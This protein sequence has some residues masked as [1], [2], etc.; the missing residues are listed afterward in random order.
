VERFFV[1]FCYTIYMEKAPGAGPEQPEEKPK[2]LEEPKLTKED[3]DSFDMRD[4]VQ[5][6][7]ERLGEKEIADDVAAESKDQ[8]GPARERAA[9]AEI[10]EHKRA[11]EELEK[12]AQGNRLTERYKEAGYNRAKANE[13][14]EQESERRTARIREL[15]GMKAGAESPEVVELTEDMVVGDAEK[16]RDKYDK[17]LEDDPS[18]DTDALNQRYEKTLDDNPDTGAEKNSEKPIEK[19]AEKPAAKKQERKDPL[20]EARPKVRDYLMRIGIRA[21]ATLI[22][23]GTLVASGKMVEVLE[24]ISGHPTLKRERA[25]EEAR[26]REQELYTNREEQKKHAGDPRALEKLRSEE[27]GCEQ[28]LVEARLQ[29]TKMQRKEDIFKSRTRS[30]EDVVRKSASEVLGK[31]DSRLKP[32]ERQRDKANEI[33]QNTDKRLARLKK[34]FDTYQDKLAEQRAVLRGKGGVTDQALQKDIE[35]LQKRLDVSKPLIGRVLKRHKQAE[36]VLKRNESTARPF[37]QQQRRF[38][39]AAGLE[40]SE[41]IVAKGSPPEDLPVMPKGGLRVVEG[42][43]KNVN[44]KEQSNAKINSFIKKWNRSTLLDGRPGWRIKDRK[45]FQSIAGDSEVLTPMRAE[46]LARKYFEDQATRK[47]QVLTERQ[48]RKAGKMGRKLAKSVARQEAVKNTI[49]K[50]AGRKKTS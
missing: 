16:L 19:T 23:R 15:E 30:I 4:R 27:E 17:T 12:D 10:A 33:L 13:L 21:G 18:V 50:L 46:H 42:G 2:A 3:Q 39:R 28:R 37:R 20:R 31:I 40:V 24:R 11:L 8:A 49:S 41:D 22:E 44:E 35:R 5:S 34:R 47:G 48:Y 14:A 6:F 38:A 43:K 45:H 7:Y 1:S 9:E 25:A 29:L 32:Y 36:G 26:A